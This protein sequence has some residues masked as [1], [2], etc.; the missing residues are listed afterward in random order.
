MITGFADEAAIWGCN[1]EILDVANSDSGLVAIEAA[2]RAR[3]SASGPP[4]G[5]LVAS[6]TAAMASVAAAERLGFKIGEDFDVVAKEAIPTLR[7]FRRQMIV[8]QEDVGAAGA[9]LSRAI[10]AL[11]DR[12]APADW[13]YLDRPTTLDAE[14]RMT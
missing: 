11:I 8:A 4:D 5:I 13:Q 6:S 1:F 12:A 7:S 3:F 10:M 2:M 14:G 9:F